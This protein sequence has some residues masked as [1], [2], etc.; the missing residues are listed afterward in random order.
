MN[1]PEHGKQCYTLSPNMLIFAKD[2]HLPT[3]SM[4]TKHTIIDFPAQGR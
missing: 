4:N 1:T 3:F 2:I